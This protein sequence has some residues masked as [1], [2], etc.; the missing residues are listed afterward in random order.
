M[1][2]VKSKR[3]SQKSHRLSYH[4]ARI[5]FVYSTSSSCVVLKVLEDSRFPSKER[6]KSLVFGRVPRKPQC[7]K[8]E[9]KEKGERERKQKTQRERKGE[10]KLLDAAC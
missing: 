3:H 7:V 6:E 4:D 5:S 8:K 1:K 9:E 10:E 2:F